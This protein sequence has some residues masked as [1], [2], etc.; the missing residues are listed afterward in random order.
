MSLNLMDC[1]GS[2]NRSFR[3]PPLTTMAPANGR[4]GVD[5]QSFGGTRPDGEVVPEPAIGCAG[6]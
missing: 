1:V 3:P 5:T 2:D 4:V 6:G